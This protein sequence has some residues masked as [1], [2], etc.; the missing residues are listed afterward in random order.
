[1]LSFGKICI[2]A[3]VTNVK[4]IKHSGN[5]LDM[6]Y[7]ALLKEI[8]LNRLSALT[9]DG[10]PEFADIARGAL[11]ENGSRIAHFTRPPVR[12]YPWTPLLE[13]LQAGIPDMK[14]WEHDD[15]ERELIFEGI[16]HEKSSGS[17]I[18]MLFGEKAGYQA[19]SIP[20]GVKG[21]PRYAYDSGK[22][23][24]LSRRIPIVSGE[25]LFRDLYVRL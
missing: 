17:R 4:L 13:S 6:D 3:V 5:I 9:E 15:R 24:Y 25:S 14:G 1:L 11:G 22:A 10:I 12:T 19:F 16:Q 7:K 23:L 21:A 2:S 8:R 20:P 18:Y